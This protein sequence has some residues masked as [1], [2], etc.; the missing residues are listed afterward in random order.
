M[1]EKYYE[2]RW[3]ISCKLFSRR[4]YQKRRLCRKSWIEYTSGVIQTD[5]TPEMKKLA[6]QAS[7]FS[8]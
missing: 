8:L 5:L 2:Y 7:F 1:E 6:L 4:P 3:S